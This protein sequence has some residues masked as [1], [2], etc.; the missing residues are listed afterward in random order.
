MRWYEMIGLP[1]S[2]DLGGLFTFMQNLHKRGVRHMIQNGEILDGMYQIIGEIGRGGT[3]IIYLAYHL[4]LQKK[5]VVKK[6]KDHFAGQIN[7]RAEVDILKRLHHSYL[8]QVYDFLVIG[9]SI[10]TVMEYVEGQDLRHY[11]DQGYQFPENTIREWLL[12]LCE[13][14]EY[15]HTQSPPILH[16]DIKPS[17]IMITAQGNIC[18]ID[19]N[20]S[21]D[22][23][24]SKDIQGVSPWF[25]AP[26]QYQKAADVLNGRTNTVVLDAR[27]DIY[28]LGAVFYTVMTG[29]LPSP[30]REYRDILSMEIP[31]SDGLCAV[32]A[33]AVKKKPSA[34]FRTAGQM[35]KALMDVSRMDPLYKK[36]TALQAGGLFA[37][38]LCMIAGALLL[39][40]GS[41]QNGVEQWQQAYRQLYIY[42]GNQ[43]D[44]AV[45][46][47]ATE[48][49]NSRTYQGYLGKHEEKKCDVL[50]LLGE[51]YFR[52]EQFKEAASYYGEAW[53]LEPDDGGL[54]RD[55]VV[56]L[57]RSGQ[58]SKG[59]LV[60]ESADGMSSLSEGEQ[61]LIQAEISRMA[62]D[63]GRAL[64]EL[65]ELFEKETDTGLLVSGY[66]LEASIYDSREE[67]GKAAASLEAAC[68]LES[69]KEIL[70]L[71]GQSAV[72]AAS[73]ESREVSGNSWLQKAFSCYESLNQM[74][75]P[76][77]EDRL[78]L[79]LVKRAMGRYQ[80]SNA[81]L[82][83]MNRIYG[84]DYVIPMWMCYNYLDLAKEQGNYDGILEDLQFRYQDCRHRYRSAG[85]TD[86]DME[87]LVS[88]M[89]DLE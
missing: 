43:E 38:V 56:A 57:V 15:L 72:K 18:L 28:S 9:T 50:R 3:G 39:Y 81:D 83:G 36:Y 75:S 30:D 24:V 62:E 54:C 71:M 8:P 86:P 16:S 55:Y 51:S 73:L 42:A 29:L 77:Y 87:E 74:N 59:R 80:D 23:E 7:G 25:A 65:E 89:K 85:K 34:R 64:E 69:S 13:V 79:A 47:Q 1:G 6:V 82:T 53:E 78:N 48:I 45:V 35:K 10:Y 44:T 66:L 33:K 22:G 41:W 19:F 58:L 61:L 12:Q 11:L 49:L 32:V 76:S 52:Q 26:E 14:L 20:I 2:L 46:S 40:Y 63:D 68:E 88:I 84:E 70:R 31:Y 17:N 5:V 37:W 27:M 4:R 21:L 67:Y 60:M